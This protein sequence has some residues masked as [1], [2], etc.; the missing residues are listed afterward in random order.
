MTQGGPFHS[1][2]LLSTYMFSTAFE[3][4]GPRLRVRHRRRHLRARPRGDHLVPR[5][6]ALGGE[7]IMTTTTLPDVRPAPS[8]TP[9]PVVPTARRRSGR[10]AARTAASTASP[11]SSRC[12]VRADPAHHRHVVPHVRRREQQRHRQHA[13]E[14]HPRD[15]PAGVEPTAACSRPLVNSLHRHDPVRRAHPRARLGRR[16]RAQPLPHP[17]RRT[18]LLLML[19]GNLLPV[20]MLLIPITRSPSSRPLRHAARAD[21]RADRVRPRVLHLRAL[22][23]HAHRAVRAAGGGGARRRRADAIFSR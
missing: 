15:L 4:P 12:V 8:P 22:R 18:I 19:A 20:Q 6:G 3:T 9:A 17:V 23:L 21:H 14:L 2:E 5:A 1:S 10:R 13:A 16:V 11:C 7:G